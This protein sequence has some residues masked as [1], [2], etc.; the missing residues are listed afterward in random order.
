MANK[1]RFLSEKPALKMI[2]RTQGE[3]FVNGSVVADPS[4]PEISYQF[5]RGSLELW[6]DEGVMTDRVDPET[7]HMVEQTAAEWLRSTP[8]FNNVIYEVVP[9]APP[10]EQILKRVT[11]AAAAGDVQALV[12][13][14]DE[15]NESWGREDVLDVIR[16]ALAR[17]EASS[18]TAA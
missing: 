16:D 11:A 14:G 7:G 1:I 13:L 9:E 12:A 5:E 4:N 10:V 8:E 6:P 18:P 3:R 17:I 15:E 2:R